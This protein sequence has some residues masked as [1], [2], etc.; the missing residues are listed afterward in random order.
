MAV[1]H[2]SFTQS[3]LVDM[4]TPLKFNVIFQSRVGD[5]VECT[6]DKI[7]FHSSDI[8]ALRSKIGGYV[9]VE[10]SGTSGLFKAWPSKKA[11]VGT[12]IM[13][14][15]WQ[16]NFTADQRKMKASPVSSARCAESPR[17]FTS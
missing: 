11:V 17:T 7:L 3:R 6:P 4:A 13:H 10:M 5:G 16:P 12:A 1:L 15:V 14:K 2:H 8:K 9:N